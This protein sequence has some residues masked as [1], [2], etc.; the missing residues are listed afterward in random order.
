MDIRVSG[1]QL[2]VGEALTAH[3]EGRMGD[4]AEKFSVGVTGSTV[5]L[6]PGPHEH[7]F[8]ATIVV[9]LAQGLLMKSHAHAYQS[10]QAAFE[11]AYERIE[12]QLRRYKR[13]LRDRERKKPEAAAVESTYRVLQSHPEEDEVPEDDAPLI[14]ADMDE[15]I[16]EVSVSDAVMMLDLKHTPAL[17]FRNG[18]TG[19][20][21]M[22]YR[23]TD[24]HI[25]W[26]EPK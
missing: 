20:L 24:G 13:K 7:E 15:H 25:G 3:A 2:D 12:K 23:R 5:T 26:V 22:V 17:M 19:S 9:Q 14:I 1:H 11:G 4:L 16:P 10:A 18:Q 21:N 6:A 8:D